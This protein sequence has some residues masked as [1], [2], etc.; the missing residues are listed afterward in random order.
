MLSKLI[1]Y[2]FRAT[3]RTFLPVY[4][5]LL[6]MS[7]VARLL[8]SG[9]LTPDGGF[10]GGWAQFLITMIMVMLFTAV[11]VITLVV[12]IRRFWQN[13]LGREGYLMNVLPVSSWQHIVSK[14]LTAAVWTILSVI[15]TVLA[16]WI[17]LGGVV[18]LAF[19]FS[20]NDFVEAWRAGISELRSA[21]AYGLSVW[22]LIQTMLNALISLAALVITIYA[23][24]CIGQTA[25]KHRGWASIG[26]YLGINTVV[27]ILT[28]WLVTGRVGH[29][30]RLRLFEDA[31]DL[32]RE[33]AGVKDALAIAN[34][35]MLVFFVYHLALAVILFFVC[36]WLMKKKLNL[37]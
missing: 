4:A 28:S 21:G 8:Y 11:W 20:W 24:M 23:A 6:V 19:E 32:F 30:Q 12:I 36:N 9:M 13:L 15:V 25:S 18:N 34:Q 29:Y 27:S 37:Q 7:V 1:K 16:F 17:M 31:P 3:G 26:A 33:P 5:I 2:E 35:E 14:L 10:S 22:L